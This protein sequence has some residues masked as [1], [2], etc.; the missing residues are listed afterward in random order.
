MNDFDG[1][2]VNDGKSKA[3]QFMWYFIGYGTD[4]TVIRLNSIYFNYLIGTN[5]EIQYV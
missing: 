2:Y 5:I 3:F 1:V 4:Q